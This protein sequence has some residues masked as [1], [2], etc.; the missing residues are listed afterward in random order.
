[1]NG[2]MMPRDARHDSGLAFARM[3]GCG[4]DFIVIDDRANRWHAQRH[5]LAHALCDRR[6]GLGGDGLLLIN[7][8][9]EVDFAMSYTNASGLEG[10]M[11]G[12]GARCIVKR[13]HDLGIIGKHTRFRTDAGLMGAD[14]D[15]DTIRLAMTTPSAAELDL[16][17]DAAGTR[18]P[19][20]GIDTGVPHLVIFTDEIETLDLARIGPPLRY[21][22]HFPRGVNPNFARRLGPNRYRMRTYERGVEAETLA[23]GTGSVAIALIAALRGEASSPVIVV[24]TG[25]GELRIDFTPRDDG[26]FSDVYLTGPAET[27]AEGVLDPHW[28]AA[29]NLA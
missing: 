23:C 8:D 12:N 14:L 21:H 28:L 29:R 26:H 1:M 9:G 2:A 25:G 19:G 4:N 10:E 22:P 3:H 7:S 15:G 6:K 16:A 11:C 18:W 5:A 27:I 13:A 20:H 17:L 24:P